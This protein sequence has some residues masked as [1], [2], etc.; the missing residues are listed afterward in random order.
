MEKEPSIPLT[1]EQQTLLNIIQ[2][3]LDSDI[4]VHTQSLDEVSVERQRL[5]SLLNDNLMRRRQRVKLDEN[6]RSLH[7]ACEL[8]T[9]VE[10]KLDEARGEEERL[11][12]DFM[13]SKAKLKKL[14]AADDQ[15]KEELDRSAEKVKELVE[16][17]DR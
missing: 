16:S 9:T 8:L 14:K 11:R 15:C 12:S 13:S 6:E 3:E 2:S 17:L 1:N 10:T 4:D 5:L 7:E